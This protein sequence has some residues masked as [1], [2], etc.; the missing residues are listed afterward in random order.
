LK[1]IPQ[2]AWKAAPKIEKVKDHAASPCREAFVPRHSNVLRQTKTWPLN[3]KG[4][5]K[6]G[7]FKTKQCNSKTIKATKEKDRE[8]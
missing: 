5:L 1:I 2:F 3:T 7:K 4:P 6:Y 8:E